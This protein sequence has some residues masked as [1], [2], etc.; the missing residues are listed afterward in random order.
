[1]ASDIAVT[2]GRAIRAELARRD[3]SQSSLA[4]NLGH[5]QPWVSRRITGDRDWT[6]TELQRVADYIG[7]PLSTF[8]RTEEPRM[9]EQIL[10]HGGDG[11]NG[12]VK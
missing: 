2:V 5:T 9:T 12:G 8:L 6:V 1:M 3:L 10:S 4:A 7:V 11:S